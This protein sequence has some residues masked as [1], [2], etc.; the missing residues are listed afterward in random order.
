[1]VNSALPGIVIK[2]LPVAPRQI[3]YS[4]GVSYFE[5]DNGNKYWEKLKTSG[6]IAVHISG[7]F[8]GL[9]LELW[10]VRSS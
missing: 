2:P 3:P 9:K 5:L 10:A 4:A 1:M 8:P 6:G 7:E